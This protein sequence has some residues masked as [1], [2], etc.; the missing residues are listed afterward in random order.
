MDEPNERITQDLLNISQ[1]ENQK[2]TN[3]VQYN[4]IKVK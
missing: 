2:S 3:I 1:K 4:Q